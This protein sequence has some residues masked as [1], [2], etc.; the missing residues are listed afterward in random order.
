[1]SK[2]IIIGCLAIATV[3]VFAE[4]KPTNSLQRIIYNSG[5]VLIPPT[6]GKS[7]LLLDLRPGDQAERENTWKPFL[8]HQE[9]LLKLPMTLKF[10]QPPKAGYDLYRTLKSFR[11]DEFPSVVMLVDDAEAP[12]IAVFPEEG[13]CAINAHAYQTD[14]VE[15][16]ARRLTRELWRSFALAMGG[17]D[18]MPQGDVLRVVAS[19]EDLDRISAPVISPMRTDGIMRMARKLQLRTQKPVSYMVACREGWAPSPTNDVQRK[20]WEKVHTIPSKPI[21]I[22]FDPKRD[23]GK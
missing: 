14:D 19:V 4:S 13:V 3:A 23:K 5:G 22:E 16:R 12:N 9:A 18:T 1:M 17:F 20:I 10:G 15:K 2:S 11:S 8:N 21:K 7:I 6:N